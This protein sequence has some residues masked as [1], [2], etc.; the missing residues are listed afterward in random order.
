MGTPHALMALALLTALLTGNAAAA[1]GDMAAPKVEQAAHAPLDLKRYMPLSEIR[2]GMKG[3]VRTVFSGR[4]IEEFEV[5]VLGV[6]GSAGPAQSAIIVRCLGDRMARTGV[7]AGMSGSP[8]YIDGRMVGALAFTWLYAREPIAGIRPIEDMLLV[9]E[10]PAAGDGEGG[11]I[12]EARAD[13]LRLRNETFSRVA[14]GKSADDDA[15]LAP[16]TL[17]MKPIATPLMVAGA[18]PATLDEIGRASCGGRV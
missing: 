3:T 10:Q 16:G 17:I 9:D 5:E 15:S 11:R 7:A 13:N 8:M 4:E 1:Q 12:I 6:L 2:A 18:S 14:I